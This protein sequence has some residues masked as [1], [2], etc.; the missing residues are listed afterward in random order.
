MLTMKNTKSLILDLRETPSGGNTTVA[1]AIMGWFVSTDHFYQKHEYYAEEKAYGVKSSWEEIVSP[2]KDKF[3]GKPLV[4]LCNH[5]TGS[6][7]EGI[8]IGF[9]GLER[10]D[11]K[12]IGTDMARLNGAVYTHE[13][14]NTKIHFTYPAERLYHINGLPREQYIPPVF[15]D[16]QKDTKNPNSDPFMAEALQYLKS[17]K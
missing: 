8:T 9:D 10:P 12:I 13:M 14:P 2:R 7:A 4:I 6:I 11:T 17:V 15:I 1:K 5:W 3:Y 16:L